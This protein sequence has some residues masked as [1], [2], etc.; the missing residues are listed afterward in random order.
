V[1][2][3]LTGDVPRG[4]RRVNRLTMPDSGVAEQCAGRQAIC[5]SPG[6]S[7]APA[8]KQDQGPSELEGPWLLV[9]GLCQAAL[10]ALLTSAEPTLSD[11]GDLVDRS[12]RLLVEAGGLIV[13]V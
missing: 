1:A 7:A 9:S 13:P 3:A 8:V 4:L 12:R 10:E 6:R 2:F 11:L 5:A